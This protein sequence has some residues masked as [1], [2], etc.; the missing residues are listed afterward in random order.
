M[1]D[2]RRQFDAFVKEPTEPQVV[3]KPSGAAFGVF[4]HNHF[5]SK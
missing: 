1:E 3:A 2:L 4:G 5:A